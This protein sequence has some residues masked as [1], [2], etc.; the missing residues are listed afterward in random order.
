V[1]TT[2]HKARTSP[3]IVTVLTINNKK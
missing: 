2:G 1:E 3:G